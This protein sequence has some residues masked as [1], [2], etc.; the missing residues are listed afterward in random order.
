MTPAG[1]L[2]PIRSPGL[3][4]GH[5]GLYE[6]RPG[7]VE[8]GDDGWDVSSGSVVLGHSLGYCGLLKITEIRP[9]ILEFLAFLR[10]VLNRLAM[11]FFRDMIL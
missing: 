2:L 4:A 9:G 11:G 10:S 6:P 7:A 8:E 1:F 3:P 5:R